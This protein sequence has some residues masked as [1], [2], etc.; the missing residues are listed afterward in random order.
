MTDCRLDDKWLLRRR[1]LSPAYESQMA[2]MMDIFNQET[3]ILNHQIEK[4]LQ[5]DVTG[6]DVYPLVSRCALDIICGKLNSC[7]QSKTRIIELI[8]QKLLPDRQSTPKRKSQT[9]PVPCSGSLK[10]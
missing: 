1:V 5:A 8:T 3:F 2:D 9:T 7:N 6:M 4:A 10:R